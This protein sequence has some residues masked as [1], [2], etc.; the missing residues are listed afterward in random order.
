MITLAAQWLGGSVTVSQPLLDMSRMNTY[1]II[2][3]TTSTTICISRFGD[4]CV[5]V[6]RNYYVRISVIIIS[7]YIWRC[8]VRGPIDNDNGELPA[9]TKKKNDQQPRQLSRSIPDG[10]AGAAQLAMHPNVRTT[11]SRRTCCCCC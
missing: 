2:Y 3:K 7:L 6:K 5:S 8:C 10:L 11:R 9:G 4:A 1:I